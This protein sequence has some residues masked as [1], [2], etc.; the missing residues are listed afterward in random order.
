LVEWLLTTVFYLEKCA[1][2][3]NFRTTY[4]IYY[5]GGMKLVIAEGKRQNIY[6]LRIHKLGGKLIHNK[7]V[8]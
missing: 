3:P 4:I 5:P 7:V 6:N 2:D 1:V 8:L